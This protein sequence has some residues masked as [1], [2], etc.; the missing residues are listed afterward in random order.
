MT[1][2]G[3]NWLLRA[4]LL[5][6]GKRLRIAGLTAMWAESQSIAFPGVLQL[7]DVRFT[8]NRFLHAQYISRRRPESNRP[9][10]LKPALWG[11]F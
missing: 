3:L 2:V 10:G 5:V 9:Q 11:C 6:A 1:L 4:V 8:V 7:A